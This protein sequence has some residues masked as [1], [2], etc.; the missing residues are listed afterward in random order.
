MNRIDLRHELQARAHELDPDFDVTT[1]TMAL[2]VHRRVTRIKR[3]RAAGAIA[4]AAAA[5]LVVGV[6]AVNSLG[7]PTPS[8]VPAGVGTA[9]P[10]VAVGRDGM[11]SRPVPMAK[12]DVTKDG[13]R[14]PA[15]LGEDSL[16]VGFIGDPGESRATLTWTP[17][18]THVTVHGDCHLPAADKDQAGRTVLRVSIAGGEGHIDRPCRIGSAT[19]TDLTTAGWTPGELG[20][21]WGQLTVGEA[22]SLQLQLVDVSTGQRV[23]YGTARVSA[24][25][26]DLGP[27]RRVFDRAG[28]LVQVLPQ[29]IEHQGYRYR[30]ADVAALPIRGGSLAIGWPVLR[31]ETPAAVPFL[32]S[33]GAIAK[34]TTSVACASVATRS[35]YC[36]QAGSLQLV[37]LDNPAVSLGIGPWT[38]A[39]QPARAAG[40]VQLQAAPNGSPVSTGTAFLALYTLER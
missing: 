21:G 4:G 15:R 18:T 14:F 3:R 26:Y 34:G 16:A 24:A 36:A 22:A 31:L 39:A 11:P 19:E 13:L 23:G 25:V 38:M 35:A 8:R 10:A 30:L 5:A 9:S 33:F 1:S 20:Q 7:N 12:G 27:Q 40:S 32:V 6:V 17:T 28:H 37:G 29:V 2:A